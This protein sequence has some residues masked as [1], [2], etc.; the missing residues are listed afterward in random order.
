MNCTKKVKRKCDQNNEPFIVQNTQQHTQTMN[1]NAT[2]RFA[3]LRANSRCY[4][5]NSAS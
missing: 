5:I 4:L 3:S 2:S 1:S